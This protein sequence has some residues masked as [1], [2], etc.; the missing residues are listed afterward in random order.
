MTQ[1]SLLKPFSSTILAII[2]FINISN[3]I[4]AQHKSDNCSNKYLKTLLDGNE[5]FV[6]NNLSQKDYKKELKEVVKGQHPYAIIVSCSDSRVPPEILFDESIGKLFIIRV[7]GNVIDPVTLGSIEYAAEHLHA[8]LLMIMGH[9]SCGAVNATIAGGET[10][11][12][13]EKI[14]QR[15]EPS[16]EKA[17]HFKEHTHLSD[18]SIEQNVKDQI[19]YC[20][21]DSPLLQEL[22]HKNELTI[23]GSIFSISTGKVTLIED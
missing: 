16:V 12:N 5:R 8:P 22:V 1:S 15:I 9:E 21:K 13:I 14:I 2:L 23:V 4:I 19:S 6:S 17:K 20:L 10:T 7:A 18:L 3:T 11:P